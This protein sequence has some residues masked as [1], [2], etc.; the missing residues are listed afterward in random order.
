MSE[1]SSKAGEDLPYRIDL[2]HECTKQGVEQ[3]VALAASAALARAIFRAAL[4]EYPDRRITLSK[5]SHVIAD[6]S[7]R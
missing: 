5:G 7:A 6:S 1:S 4:G 3:V 2:W